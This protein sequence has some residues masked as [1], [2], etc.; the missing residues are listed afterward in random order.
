MGL[1]DKKKS[2]ETESMKLTGKAIFNHNNGNS[3]VVEIGSFTT[4]Q[5]QW[6]KDNIGRDAIWQSKSGA[7]NLKYFYRVY[8]EAEE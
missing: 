8:F 5:M 2:T 3:S 6:I 7:I 1:F 4:D